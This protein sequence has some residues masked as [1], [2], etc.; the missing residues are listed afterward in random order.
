MHGFA[1]GLY[2]FVRTHQHLAGQYTEVWILLKM[3]DRFSKRPRLPVRIVIAE[4][5]KG[6]L[7]RPNADVAGINALIFGFAST[8]TVGNCAR[9]RSTVPS[10]E[11][12]S[13]TRMG[14]FSGSVTK[15]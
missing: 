13:T 15:C 10:V 7:S 8:V 9:T 11:Q 14:G 1:N 5:N 6:C 12:L 3:P 2:V 4:S